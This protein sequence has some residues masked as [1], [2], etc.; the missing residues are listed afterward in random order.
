MTLMLFFL[1]SPET[2]I[3]YIHFV[4]KDLEGEINTWGFIGASGFKKKLN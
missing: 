4:F 2:A 1:N 3:S